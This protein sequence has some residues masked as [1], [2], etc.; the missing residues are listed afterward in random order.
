MGARHHGQT[1]RRWLA[2]LLA[3][4]PTDEPKA[5]VAVGQHPFVLSMHQDMQQSDVRIE[6]LTRFM[7]GDFE[8]L[9]VFAAQQHHGFAEHVGARFCC[10]GSGVRQ[11]PRFPAPFFSLDAAKVL[12]DPG[13]AAEGPHRAAHVWRVERARLGDAVTGDGVRHHE[14]IGV[15]DMLQQ[16]EKNAVLNRHGHLRQV[17]GHG[18]CSPSFVQGFACL[19]V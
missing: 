5:N 7:R 10:R 6:A 4:P 8:E 18:S 11:L 3:S 19:M 17:G 12:A 1:S 13:I 2:V 15:A 14:S 9:P 16:M